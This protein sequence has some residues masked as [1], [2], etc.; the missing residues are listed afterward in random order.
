MIYAVF[1]KFT[2]IL[3]KYKK[4]FDNGRKRWYYNDIV[5]ESCNQEIFFGGNTHERYSEVV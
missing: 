2:N 1:L 5:A 4:M 3:R